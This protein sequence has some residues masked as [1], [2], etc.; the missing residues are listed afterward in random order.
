MY[1]EYIKWYSPSLQKDMELLVFGHG[2]AAI[3]FFPPRM[4]RFYDYENWGVIESLRN[5]IEKGYI[6]VFCMDSDDCRG[7]YNYWLHPAQ[8]IQRA[9]QSEQSII[10]EVVP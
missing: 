10:N 9:V 4:G 2:G 5:K 6:Q 1:R 8:K 7:F 3:I